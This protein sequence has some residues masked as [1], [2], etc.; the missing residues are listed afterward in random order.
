MTRPLVSFSALPSTAGL[1]EWRRP[2]RLKLPQ[3]AVRLCLRQPVVHPVPQR[4]RIQS[5]EEISAPKRAQ[6]RGA[7]GVQVA[8]EEVRAVGLRAACPS[9][10]RPAWTE[11]RQGEE[12]EG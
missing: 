2:L 3:R 11:I 4:H 1:V 8:R 12:D 9:D 5:F 7:V 6:A 10:D